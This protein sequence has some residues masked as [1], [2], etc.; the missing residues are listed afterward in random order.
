MEAFLLRINDMEITQILNQ[1]S[2]ALRKAALN[3]EAKAYLISNP[4]LFT[5]I[6]KAADRYI[7]GETLEETMGKVR[8]QT[9][10]GF[11]CSIEYMGES[12]T[13]KI[14]AD[15]ARDEFISVCEEIKRSG[16]NATVSLDL[17]H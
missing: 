12:T 4:V 14:E 2:T 1:A 16:L 10:H 13:T 3:E 6:K 9:G 11:K 7:G 8:L 15:K 17:S 5:F